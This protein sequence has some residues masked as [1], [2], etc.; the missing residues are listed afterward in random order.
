M[1]S[2]NKLTKA[3][4]KFLV[5]LPVLVIVSLISIIYISYL[6]TYIFVLIKTQS[7]SLENN[8]FVFI[9]TLKPTNA[10]SKGWTL[11]VIS[12]VLVLMLMLCLLRT[13]FMDPGYMPSPMELEYKVVAKNNGTLRSRE[14]RQEEIRRNSDYKRLSED[15]DDS[16]L[17]IKISEEIHNKFEYIT[18]FDKLV[19]NGP[20]TSHETNEIR[21]RVYTYFPHNFN[22]EILEKKLASNDE[23]IEVNKRNLYEISK[24][25]MENSSCCSLE[26]KGQNALVKVYEGVDLSTTKL[27]SFC[28]RLKV[29]RSHHCRMCGRCILKMDHHCPWLANC[30]G[31]RNYK[32]FCL[33][34]LYGVLSTLL[35]A[36]TYWEVVLNYNLNYEKDLLSCWYVFF[37]YAANLGLLIFCL[38]LLTVNCNLLFSGLTIIEQAEKDK[39]QVK[40][41]N[42]YDMG[43]KRN[44]TNVFGTS[45]LVW[46]T[47]FF[48]NYNGQGLVY[49]SNGYYIS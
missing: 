15:L 36:L 39:L 25:K 16:Q 48:A 22:E 18:K 44:F 14:E 26:V 27:C 29:E 3:Y 2:E 5:Y 21:E 38:W 10:A 4:H 19:L 23:I 9:H 47:P 37:V 46:F 31:F 17:T 41:N 12:I 30:I 11:L 49:E 35:I 34:H 20:M 8:D 40:S 42:I 1:K 43:W 33:L 13:V 24:K 45:P 7:E 28:L 32:S 6:F